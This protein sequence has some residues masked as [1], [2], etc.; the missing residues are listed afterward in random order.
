MNEIIWFIKQFF[1][2]DYYSHYKSN[3]KEMVSTWKMFL[4]KCYN[5]KKYEIR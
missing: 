4:G 2:L 5:I 3:G 1:P